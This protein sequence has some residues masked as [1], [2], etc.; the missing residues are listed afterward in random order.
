MPPES[1]VGDISVTPE[2]TATA[3]Y[4]ASTHDGDV[5]KLT[6]EQKTFIVRRLACFRS[7]T[8]V[9]LDVEEEFGVQLTRDHVRTYN[10]LQVQVSKKWAVL[11]EATRKAFVEEVG[12]EGI[13]HQSFRLRELADLYRRAKNR[14]NDVLA[15]QLLEQ[16]AKEAGGAF[17]NR[18]DNFNLDL[19]SLTESQLERVAAGEDIR[20]VVGR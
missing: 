7:P 11:F 9:C 1:P 18:R 2:R 19:T 5:A 20:K 4:R 10:P 14:K 8:E 13:A 3:L 15:A 17:T 16:A 12:Q 6:E